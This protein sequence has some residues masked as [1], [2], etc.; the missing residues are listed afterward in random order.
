MTPATLPAV[1]L[2]QMRQLSDLRLQR[3]LR[4]LQQA[5]K[6]AAEARALVRALERQILHCDHHLTLHSDWLCGPDIAPT[7]LENAIASQALWRDRRLKL[8][9]QQ[10]DAISA[11][12]L[13][14][15]AANA[16]AQAVSRAEARLEIFE[17]DVRRFRRSRV[18]R[19]DNVEEVESM[20]AMAGHS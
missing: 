3:A 20:I 5:Q 11:Q 6:N 14:D 7:L 17:N 8:I 13:A 2:G 10:V 1:R 18:D 19:I 9:Q 12:T 4:R 15:A 16:A